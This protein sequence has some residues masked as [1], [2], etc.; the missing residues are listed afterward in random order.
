MIIKGQVFEGNQ[1]KLLNSLGFTTKEGTA[2]KGY[3]YSTYKIDS[4]TYIW[5]AYI[6]GKEHKG[7]KNY[8]LNN[9]TI[10]I[11][12]KLNNKY[13]PIG[14][15]HPYRLVFEKVSD[16]GNKYHF[17]FKGVYKL[18]KESTDRKRILEKVSDKI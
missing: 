12:E 5:M 2:F 13:H 14:L 4:Q 16:N 6:H 17:V 9:Q 11:E 7:W 3:R 18:K 8:Y 1:V 10:I 15:T